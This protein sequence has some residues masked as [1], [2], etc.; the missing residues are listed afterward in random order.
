MKA[1]THYVILRDDDTNALTPVSCLERLYRPFLAHD[2]A[3]NLAVIP[4]VR[5]GLKR[6]DGRRE[7]FL[8]AA[9]S[10][11]SGAET[12][13]LAGNREL[14]GYLRANPGLRLVQ[15]GCYHDTFE[16][17]R[18][19]RTEVGA[20]MERGAWRFVEA[21]FPAPKTFVAPHDRFSRTSM[22]EAARRFPVVS[23]GWFDRRRLPLA[24]WPRYLA[25]KL[26]H[27]AHWRAGGACL[28][29]HPGC[30]LSRERPH[31]NMLERVQAAVRSR[32][33]TVLVT[34]WW[35]YFPDGR[36]DDA[37]IAILHATAAWLA[38]QPDVEVITFEDLADGVVP[39]D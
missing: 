10:P 15:H 14:T 7:G 2:L 1:A 39:L 25:A 8:F 19:D 4:E 21:G 11:G 36:P 33:L 13:P 12:F 29:S 20:R 35:E 5:T 37:F 30:L 18:T 27:A 34:H 32:R 23:T 26:H 31:Q 6:P 9:P 38:N 3:V 16:F 28:L 17:D 24:W 22:E